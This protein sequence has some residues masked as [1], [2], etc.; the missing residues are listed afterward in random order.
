MANESRESEQAHLT[1]A[2]TNRRTFLRDGLSLV[3]GTA[4]A[5]VAMEMLR[6][7]APALADPPT[8]R[9]NTL[10]PTCLAVAVPGRRD[11]PEE[12]QADP[13]RILTCDDDSKVNLWRPKKNNPG[14]FLRRPFVKLHGD[15][16][17][18]VTVSGDTVL[19]ASYD[20]LVIVR[21]LNDRPANAPPAFRGHRDPGM[22]PPG[23]EAEV[24]VAA[25]STNGDRALSGDNFGNILYWN[26]RIQPVLNPPRFIH[27]FKHEDEWVA[28]LA[29]MPEPPGTEQKRF[30]SG[31]ENGKMVL[32]NFSTNPAS[33]QK[34][35]FI[36]PNAADPNDN[37]PVNTVA[38]ISNDFLVSAGFDGK[39]RIWEVANIAAPTWEIPLGDVVVWRVAISDDNKTLAAATQ[40]FGT[41]GQVRLFNISDLTV[42]PPALPK[43]P[44]PE[45]GGV[46]GVGFLDNERIVYTTG[47]AG[48]D[49]IKV[50]KFAP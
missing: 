33:P 50:F 24:L 17:T 45:D 43:Q 29:F 26:T 48:R 16:A 28:A 30:L 39:V 42:E 12:P 2:A 23:R 7:P 11:D 22:A 20:G 49:H 32:W 37:Y 34:T 47:D 14:Q 9:P 36:H 44:G 10:R 46:M 1:P 19:T 35:E 38:V 31:H 21:D 41:E 13:E 18:Y 15:K 40:N 5:S 6:D 4:L 3:G 25:L 27:Q 8:E